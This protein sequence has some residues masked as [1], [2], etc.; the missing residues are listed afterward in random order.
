MDDTRT[1]TT[2]LAAGGRRLIVGWSDGTEHD[3]DL[4]ARAEAP[5]DDSAFAQA[6]AGPDRVCW[7]AGGLIA[8]ADL[9]E[10]GLAQ[11]ADRLIGWRTRHRLTQ[12]QACAILGIAERM[13]RNYEKR[14]YP[15]PKAILLAL[16]GYDARL[17][18]PVRPA[19]ERSGTPGRS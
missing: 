14:A 8:A 5:A 10:L 16:D 9:W 3:L 13:L 11:A 12:P 6:E 4:S 19:P 7:P 17:G 1:I 18:L 2:L 15:I